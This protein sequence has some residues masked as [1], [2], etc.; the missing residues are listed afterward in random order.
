MPRIFICSSSSD[1]RD[2]AHLIYRH[3][4]Q[5]LGP[6]AVVMDDPGLLP[7]ERRAQAAARIA[8]SQVVLAI[9]GLRQGG[10]PQT[11]ATA[12]V[13]EFVRET[14]EVARAAKVPVI[15]VLVAGADMAAP[16][17]LLDGLHDVT[18]HVAM[19]EI[20]A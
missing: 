5:R 20:A 16:W 18:A 6:D 12:D 10:R 1:L 19:V 11:P 14:T 9:V 4:D 17:E 15:L 3:F 7:D 2:S 13:S 8:E